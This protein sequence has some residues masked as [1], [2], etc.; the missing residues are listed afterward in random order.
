[1]TEYITL[2]IMGA[3]IGYGTNWLAIKMIF[4][5]YEEKHIFGVR[6]PFTPGVMAKE[7]YNFSKK[8]GNTLSDNVITE[9]ELAKYFQNIDFSSIVKNLLSDINVDKPLSAFIQEEKF[10]QVLNTSLKTM[11]KTSLSDEEKEA[12]AKVIVSN[13]KGKLQSDALENFLTKEEQ[14]EIINSFKNN[15]EVFRV[16][17]NLVTNIFRKT[18]VLDKPIV[19]VLGDD[20]VEKL[21]KTFETNGDRIR[22]ALLEYVKSEDF[23]YFE[24]KIEELVSAGVGKIPIAAMF[25]GS[26][27]GKMVTPILIENAIEYLEDEEHNEEIVEVGRHIL[28][29]LLKTDSNKALEFVSQ[30]LIFMATQKLIIETCNGLAETVKTGTT[31]FEY[32]SIFKDTIGV[33]EG[34]LENLVINTIDNFLED[35]EKLD[36]VSTAV[37]ERI[38]DIKIS[39]FMNSI[40]EEV[41]EQISS[42]LKVALDKNLSTLLKH[43]NIS[44]IV[45]NKINTFE[46]K[47]AERLVVDVMNKELKM[48]T[49]LGGVLGFI[50]GCISILI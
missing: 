5:P 49:S 33:L 30:D 39:N 24:G 18:E 3:I 34:K 46:M 14:V 19:D 21:L 6:V 13:I 8:L 45:E 43:I 31:T 25:G 26:A 41:V 35:E 16:A 29:N 44:E 23:K 27:L 22:L 4:R 10:V 17:N 9:E 48:I 32:K 47:E 15:D 11:I 37:V 20:T 50:I 1:M 7:R 2:P 12:V 42:V 36:K 40:S 38:A 28:D